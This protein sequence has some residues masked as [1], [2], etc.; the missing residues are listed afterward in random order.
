M[1]ITELSI[2]RASG[3]WRPFSFLKVGTD[4]GLVGWSEFLEGPWSPALADVIMQLGHAVRGSDPR[5]WAVRAAE[6]TAMTRFTAG[7]LSRQAVSAIENACVDIAA[8]AAGVPACALVGGPF[9]DSVDVYWSHCGTFRV[10]H[11]EL[12]RRTIGR[13]PL[14]GI[15]D[16]RELGREAA[17]RGFGAVKINPVL[18]DAGGPRLLNPGFAIAG[19]DHAGTLDHRT[20]DAIVAQVAA[21]REGLGAGRGLM[22]DVN[23]AFRPEALRR[24]ARA[25]C[26]IAPGWTP[27]WLELDVPDAAALASV[28]GASGVPIASL[29]AAYGRSGYQPYLAAQ[30][31]DVAVVDVLWNGFGEAVRIAALAETHQMNIAPHNFQGPIADLISAHFCAAVPNATIMEYEGDDVPW[32]HDLVDL[33]SPLREGRFVVPDRPG[34]GANVNED[35]VREHPWQK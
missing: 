32:K 14:N 28:R 5:A 3:G 31:V 15:D 30:A 29:E 24:L 35:A 11:P 12:F 22:L 26:A 23:F 27:Q 6:L 19:L 34:W 16:L 4:E 17:Q 7:G 2:L 9:R 10:R 8:K 1:R 20:L 18:F 21:V 33:P 25:L 13:P